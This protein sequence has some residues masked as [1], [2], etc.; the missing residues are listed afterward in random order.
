MKFTKYIALAGAAA[1][2]ASCQEEFLKPEPLSFFEP[3]VTFSTESGLRSSMAANDRHLRNYYTWYQGSNICTPLNAMYLH[4]ELA[5]AC[6]TDNNDIWIDPAVRLTPSSGLNGG[7]NETNQFG[8]WWDETYIGIRNANTIISYIDKVEGLDEATKNAYLGRAYFHRSF[9]YYVLAFLFKDVPLITKL[10]ETP[11]FDYKTTSREAILD[12]MTADMEFA[13]K[14]VPDQSEMSEMGEINKDACKML[15]SKLY[16][17]RGEFDKAISLL[18]EVIAAHPLLQGDK[19]GDFYEPFNTV[20]VPITRNLIWD[21]HRPENRLRSDNTELILGMPNRG[22]GSSNSFVYWYT[23]RGWQPLW[24]AAVISDSN[25]KRAITA[26]ARNNDN[27]REEYDYLRAVGRGVGSI[28][29]TYFAQH[30][31]WYVNDKMDE[32][33]LRRSESTGNWMSVAQMRV[34]NPASAEFGQ[35]LK[36]E[37]CTDTIRSW[38]GWPNYKLYMYDYGAEASKSSTQFNGATGSTGNDGCADWYLYRSAEAYLLRAEAKFYKGL[39]GAEDVNAVRRRAGCTQLYATVN[40]GDIVNERAR[41]LYMEEFHWIEM[42][43][44]SY[45]LAKTGKP[46]E[47]GNTYDLSTYDTQSGTE[48][49]GGSY[50]YQRIMHYN[51]FMGINKDPN[52][53][54]RNH[55]FSI[56]K[57]NLYLP[58]PQK[59][60]DANTHARLRQNYGYDGYSPD[61]EMFTTWEEAV[62]DE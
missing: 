21:M 11:K 8:Y 52:I 39:D 22:Q 3:G 7:N 35:L 43:R 15:L 44:I 31:L 24:D 36:Q 19:F 53:T 34:N 57:H 20:T 33:D 58:I 50:W 5:V 4:S 60:I 12:K 16:M 9:R 51:D 29:P 10:I 1:S 48:T 23:M 18:D 56:D 49:T 14:W 17:T 2:L 45:C 47:W 25:G 13:V 55:K 32:G 30:S 61:I 38:S 62:A 59:A 6:K 26:Y 41:E 28:R 54:I 46:D 40:I 27:Y 42:S 37:N